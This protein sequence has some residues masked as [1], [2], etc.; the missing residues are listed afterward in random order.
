MEQEKQKVEVDIDVY[1]RIYDWRNSLH[2]SKCAISLINFLQE[3]LFSKEEGVKCIPH[4]IAF[5]SHRIAFDMP[6]IYYMRVFVSGYGVEGKMSSNKKIMEI[7]SIRED[8]VNYVCSRLEWSTDRWIQFH[9]PIERLRNGIVAHFDATELLFDDDNRGYS[10]THV[11]MNPPAREEL[12]T[13]IELMRDYLLRF[14]A[15]EA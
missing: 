14:E 15:S 8:M 4:E 6:A 12:C 10:H 2:N 1:N 3:E 11:L 5:H 9:T 7:E 13:V